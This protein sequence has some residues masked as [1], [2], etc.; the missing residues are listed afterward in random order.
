MTRHLSCISSFGDR[1]AIVEPV[2]ARIWQWL[3][4]LL[5]P[6]D[7]LTDVQP[8]VNDLSLDPTSRCML[9]VFSFLNSIASPTRA[10][11]VELGNFTKKLAAQHNA[12]SVLAKVWVACVV[13][14]WS[15]LVHHNVTQFLVVFCRSMENTPFDNSFRVAVANFCPGSELLPVWSTAASD[16]CGQSPHPDPE[17]RLVAANQ[18]M[19]IAATTS[20][21]QSFPTLDKVDV[22]LNHV[23]ILWN[24]C[25][26]KTRMPDAR[27]EDL[28]SITIY[29]LAR[30]SLRLI[31]GGGPNW[32]AKALHTNLLYLVAK[33][34]DWMQTS[35]DVVAIPGPRSRGSL[36]PS[37]RSMSVSIS[38]PRGDTPSKR[39][40]LDTVPTPSTSFLEELR[41][42]DQNRAEENRD[43]GDALRDLREELLGLSDSHPIPSQEPP[44]TPS[45]PRYPRQP[46]YPQ[47]PYLHYAEER[48]G[49]SR[50]MSADENRSLSLAPSSLNRTPS[51]TSSMSFLSSH[52]SDDWLLYPRPQPPG[53]PVSRR[54]I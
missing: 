30:F 41:Q 40:T 20:I 24:R 43:L 28:H 8:V 29:F 31:S 3:A 42:Y 21:F 54:S 12:I 50:A 52:H 22:T 44:Q 45:C 35:V 33:T 51:S 4:A 27:F 17:R 16:L 11:L 26:D 53:S 13:K 18:G 10:T 23:Y 48:V 37:E 19:L 38:T 39:S 15:L 25:I 34:M 14:Q 9:T 32:I 7:T 46:Q 1:F 36:T 5:K 2:W 49:S 47:Q 6:L